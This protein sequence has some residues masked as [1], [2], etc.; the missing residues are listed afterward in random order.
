[1]KFKK[2][3]NSQGGATAVAARLGLSSMAVT[4]WLSGKSTPK[5]VL[6]QKLVKMGRGAF[7]FNDIIGE[8]KRGKIKRS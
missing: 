2:W 4:Q 7:D 5:A 3:V 8:T 1:M 6:M